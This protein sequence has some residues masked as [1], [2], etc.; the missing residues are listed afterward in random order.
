MDSGNCD[1]SIERHSYKLVWFAMPTSISLH[2]LP[3]SKA[4]AVSSSL[5][6]RSQQRSTIRRVW[7]HTILQVADT[8]VNHRSLTFLVHFYGPQR[9]VAKRRSVAF[10]AMQTVRQCLSGLCHPFPAVSTFALKPMD[11]RAT[12]GCFQSFWH[13]RGS[14]LAVDPLLTIRLFSQVVARPPRVCRL[15][16]FLGVR[17][18]LMFKPLATAAGPYS[19]H[20]RPRC[21]TKGRHGSASISCACSPSSPLSCVRVSEPVMADASTITASRLPTSC[22]WRQTAIALSSVFRSRF[23]NINSRISIGSDGTGMPRRSATT[24]YSSLQ[25][26]FCS[27]TISIRH[28]R[29]CYVCRNA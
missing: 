28:V 6:L 8:R 1:D 18:C 25:C 19:Q 9:R 27:T 5:R 13:G 11:D 4:S 3:F 29:V 23:T 24:L 15:S 12:F 26:L 20:V 21:V 7:N 10:L 14:W 17:D 16:R 22:Q 2:S